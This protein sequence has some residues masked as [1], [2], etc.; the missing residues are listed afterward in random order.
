MG[1]VGIG[2]GRIFGVGEGALITAAKMVMFQLRRET[3]GGAEAEVNARL[4][5]DVIP[6]ST[7][8]PKWSVYVTLT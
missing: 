5:L 3:F 1:D 7:L 4:F 6:H 8:D 2:L